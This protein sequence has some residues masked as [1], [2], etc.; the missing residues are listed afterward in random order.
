MPVKR[1]SV[2]IKRN[3]EHL[4]KLGG[5]IYSK[6]QADGP[7]SPLNALVDNNWEVTGPK[8][9]PCLA[10]HLKAEELKR[11]MATPTYDNR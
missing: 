8:I 10:N 9:A 11:Q 3:P 2:A 1:G 5:S 7:A 6:H 4:I